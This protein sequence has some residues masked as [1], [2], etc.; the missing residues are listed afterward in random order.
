[1]M[2][3]AYR[4]R[5]ASGRTGHQQKSH[6][7]KFVAF[8]FARRASDEAVRLRGGSLRCLLEPKLRASISRIQL[9]GLR[10]KPEQQRQ[11]PKQ[12]RRPKRQRQ[13]PKQQP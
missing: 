4:E 13:H 12:R 6:E 7:R 9:T 1:M 11:R 3:A 2:P 8:L 5:L 10:P